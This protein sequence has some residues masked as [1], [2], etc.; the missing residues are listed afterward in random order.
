M[1]N[2]LNVAK[3]YRK[4]PILYFNLNMTGNVV[5]CSMLYNWTQL[6]RKKG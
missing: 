6:L 3:T 5:V 4:C 2:I 1:L